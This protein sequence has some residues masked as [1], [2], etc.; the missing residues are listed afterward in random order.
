MA[1]GRGFGGEHLEAVRLA[2][3]APKLLEALRAGVD[4][5]IPTTEWLRMARAAIKAVETGKRAEAVPGLCY[6]HTDLVYPLRLTQDAKGRFTVTYGKQVV[7]CQSYS[8]AAAEYGSCLMHALACE[9][10]LNNGGTR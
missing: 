9:G 5:E 3:G 8:E 2:N 7:P 4:N 10:R 6:E 1:D